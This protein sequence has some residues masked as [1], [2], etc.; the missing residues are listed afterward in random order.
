[1]TTPVLT[2]CTAAQALRRLRVLRPLGP[3]AALERLL[4]LRD[5]AGILTLFQR[6]FPAEFDEALERRNGIE[7][8]AAVYYS[9]EIEF[10]K[11]V[12]RRLFPLN[13]EALIE[14][15]ERFGGPPIAVQAIEGEMELRPGLRVLRALALR[16]N[17][18][19]VVEWEAVASGCA[20]TFGDEL[21]VNW[22]R[23]AQRCAQLSRTLRHIRRILAT[24]ANDA[25]NLWTDITWEMLGYGHVQTDWTDE[26][27]DWLAGP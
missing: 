3:R 20:P 25:G 15:E 7:S 8:P 27:L 26:S 14:A 9:L 10:F 18:D 22:R 6:R 13:V 4:G 19:Q 17:S 2:C 16:P 11:L 24:A 12:E 21:R 5:S 1:M 23:F